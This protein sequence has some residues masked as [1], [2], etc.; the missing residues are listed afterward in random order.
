MKTKTFNVSFQ[1]T[2]FASTEVEA[3]SKSEAEAIARKSHY[4]EF[5]LDKHTLTP[6]TLESVSEVKL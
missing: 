5:D 2:I 6:E 3:N 1:C 4:T